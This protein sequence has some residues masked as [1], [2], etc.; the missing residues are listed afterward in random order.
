MYVYLV[1]GILPILPYIII[2]LF[3][4]GTVLK[5]KIK[6]IILRYYGDGIIWPTVVVVD[7]KH[8]DNNIV[9]I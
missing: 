1:I 5:A 3:T 8:I 2:I 6:F 4:N 9:M 7:R